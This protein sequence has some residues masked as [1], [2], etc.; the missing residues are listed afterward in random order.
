M[1]SHASAGCFVVFVIAATSPPEKVANW[2]SS[3]PGIGARPN[4]NAGSVPS[5]AVFTPLPPA[6][7]MPT[8]PEANTEKNPSPVSVFA[9]SGRSPFS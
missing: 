8:L 3:G 2:P 9:V 5:V 4:S 1:K 7:S 6:K